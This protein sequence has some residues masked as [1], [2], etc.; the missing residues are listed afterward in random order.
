MSTP[1][2]TPQFPR[3]IKLT[4]NT[5]GEVVA[6]PVEGTGIAL[7]V[8]IHDDKDQG[9]PWDA[10]DGHGP[11]RDS[12]FQR[13][14]KRAGERVLGF[15]GDRYTYYDFQAACRLARTDWGA[16]TRAEAT[17]MAE[18]DFQRLKAW[19]NDGWYWVGGGSPGAHAGDRL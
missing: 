19:C 18:Q 11:V 16:R 2:T 4:V 1:D 14:A 7:C 8:T 12:L 10:H 9:P 6:Y 13:G 17:R 3:D 15:D 5:W